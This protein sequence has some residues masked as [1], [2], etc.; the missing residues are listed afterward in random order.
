M[1]ITKKA[2]PRRALLQ[3]VGASLAL[4]LLDAMIPAGV[5]L[6]PRSSGGPF[7]KADD[8]IASASPPAN[9]RVRTTRLE[10]SRLM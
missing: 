10:R 7:A 4:P 6:A 3:G 8:D 9:A 5:A 2:L 1:I